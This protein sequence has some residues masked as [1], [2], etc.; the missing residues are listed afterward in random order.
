[1]L[2]AS[3]THN[4]MCHI[5]ARELLDLNF[6]LLVIYKISSFNEI[7]PNFTFL[8][9]AFFFYYWNL[10]NQPPLPYKFHGSNMWGIHFFIFA[11]CEPLSDIYM[12]ELT[13]MILNLEKYDALYIFH[14]PRELS[15][16]KQN[17]NKNKNKNKN[18]LFCFSVLFYFCFVFFFF[19]FLFFRVCL[20]LY[21]FCVCLLVFLVQLLIIV[22]YFSVLTIIDWHVY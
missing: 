1:M 3:K 12:F 13:R 6:N 5:C 18:L 14:I 4:N 7:T 16:K 9:K 21:L 10:L 11:S 19:F 2:C 17:K 22:F 15:C 8:Q 20:K